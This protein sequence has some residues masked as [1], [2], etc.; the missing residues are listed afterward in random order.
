[1]TGP[2]RRRRRGRFPDGRRPQQ[3]SRSPRGRRSFRCGRSSP[4]VPG[5]VPL[6]IGHPGGFGRSSMTSSPQRPDEAGRRSS[7]L[8]APRRTPDQAPGAAIGSAA[9]PTIIGRIWFAVRSVQRPTAA[10]SALVPGARARA[11]VVVA[12]GAGARVVVVVATGAGTRV[13]V[14]VATGARARVVVVV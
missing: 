10:G 6:R 11:V 2:A 9:R 12:T 7:G 14:V 5:Q 4:T 3:S 13:G 8:V 1:M